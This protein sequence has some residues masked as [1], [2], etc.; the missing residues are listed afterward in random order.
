MQLDAVMIFEPKQGRKTAEGQNMQIL[1]NELFE[2]CDDM[3]L[4]SSHTTCKEKKSYRNIAT[5]ALDFQNTLIHWELEFACFTLP[6]FYFLS[7]F[8][9]YKCIEI[10][11]ES[12][13]KS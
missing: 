7:R 9:N 11:K 3:W 12:E 1:L 10:F 13:E 8:K 4:A 5:F 2:D 6:L